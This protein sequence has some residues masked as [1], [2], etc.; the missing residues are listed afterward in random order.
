MKAVTI[1]TAR[2]LQPLSVNSTGVSL[3][4][5]ASPDYLGIGLEPSADHIC[6]ED[7]EGG[8]VTGTKSNTEYFPE[9]I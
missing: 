4:V 5:E 9:Q 3:V 1:T 7:S 6:D 2:S 8:Q